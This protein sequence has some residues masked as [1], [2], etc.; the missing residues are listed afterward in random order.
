ML[1]DASFRIVNSFY[2]F[3]DSGNDRLRIVRRCEDWKDSS[4]LC[5]TLSRCWSARDGHGVITLPHH[6]NTR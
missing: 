4:S 2:E 6:M 3:P 5:A 1:D